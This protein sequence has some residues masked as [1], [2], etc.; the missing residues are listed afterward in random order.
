MTGRAIY[1]RIDHDLDAL[2]LRGYVFGRLGN[3]L[4]AAHDADEAAMLLARSTSP[5]WG[6]S[7]SE[8]PQ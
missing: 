1:D 4:A 5:S 6:H 7:L 2:A 3:R 8:D